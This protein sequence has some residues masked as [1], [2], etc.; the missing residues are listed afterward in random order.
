MFYFPIYWEYSSQLIKFFQ[1]GRSTTNQYKLMVT[2]I[3]FIGKMMISTSGWNGGP[4]FQTNPDTV[5]TK[6]EQGGR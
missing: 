4:N 5:T 1:R 2:L 3:M 6:K